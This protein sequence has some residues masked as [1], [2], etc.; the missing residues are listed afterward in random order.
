MCSVTLHGNRTYSVI[1]SKV[2]IPQQILQAETS[3]HLFTFLA[4]QIETFLKTN[5]LESLTEAIKYE[6]NL[7]LGF[8]FS[9]TVSQLNINSGTLIQW[10]KGFNIKDAIG[11]DVC[12]LLQEALQELHLPVKV[13]T[14]VNDTVGT[15]MTRAYTSP[16]P[17]RTMLG[18]VF[19]TGTNCAYIERLSDIKKLGNDP[20]VDK[21]A[22][23]MI[24]N[25][26]WGG[27]DDTLDV[28]PT[29]SFDGALDENSINPGSQL[30]EKRIAGMYLGEIFRLAV[31]K[32]VED[33][34][35]IFRE[36]NGIPVL[37]FLQRIISCCTSWRK[38]SRRNIL[39]EFKSTLLFKPWSLDSEVLSVLEADQSK[40][41]LDSRKYLLQVLGVPSVKKSD[42]HALKTIAHAIGRRSA[43]LG[44]V[45]IGAI[46]LHIEILSKNPD[47]SNSQLS[48]EKLKRN[49]QEIDIGVDGSLIEFYPGFEK[50]LRGALKEIEGIGEDGEERV[51]IGM[52]KDGSGVGAALTAHMVETGK[53][54]GGYHGKLMS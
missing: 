47:G 10:D 46:I 9:Y 4:K 31:V 17:G 12:K 40:D 26:E 19:G 30:L 34:I 32:L 29:T 21:M 25:T 35:P 33:E 23:E 39:D 14:L 49:L 45:G 28:L 5:K 50:E 51:Y 13:V 42:A 1:Q 52:A 37:S 44:G 18:A 53:I 54:M 38:D 2:V 24:L 27:F 15:L 8:T 22:N 48:T 7:S 36:R 11:K 41:L 3:S 6:Q 43:R 20:N 16:E